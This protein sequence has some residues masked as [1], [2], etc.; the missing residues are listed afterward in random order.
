MSRK[1][2]RHVVTEIDRVE[3][4]VQALEQNKS[5]FKSLNTVPLGLS[6]DTVPSK[7]AWADHLEIKTLRLLS[8]FWPHGEVA[9]AY[10]IFREK[11][12]FSERAN[13]TVDKAG[14][15]AFVKVYEIP[16]LP[17]IAEIIGVLRGI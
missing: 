5:T 6:V 11:N 17:D 12:G 13:I 1:S 2:A 9:K 16:Q 14:K 7:K 10:G 15:I 4:T 8:D 3:Q